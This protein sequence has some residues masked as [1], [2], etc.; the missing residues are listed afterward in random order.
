MITIQVDEAYAFDML[1]ILELKKNRSEADETNYDLF[2]S[3]IS[4]Q[5]G[6]TLT[7]DI[8]ISDVYEDLLRANKEVFDYVEQI[9]AGD[10]LDAA[11]VHNSNMKRFHLKKKLQA[12]FFGGDLNERKTVK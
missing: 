7:G 11:I 8:M 10:S 12:S 5:V 4:R 6:M 2:L 3:N 1:A 9:C